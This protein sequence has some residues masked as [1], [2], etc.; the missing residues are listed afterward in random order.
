MASVI[1][2]TVHREVVLNSNESSKAMLKIFA[3]LV[4]VITPPFVLFL[5]YILLRDLKNTPI[6][7][8][9]DIFIIALVCLI[10]F[11]ACL[12]YCQNELGIFRKK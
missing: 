4:V 6:F 11:V 5:A 12:R 3:P 8:L 1:I 9:V 2:A 7:D 10:I